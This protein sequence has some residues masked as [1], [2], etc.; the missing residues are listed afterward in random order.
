MG[1]AGIS[2]LKGLARTPSVAALA[3][4]QVLNVLIAGPIDERAY[5]NISDDASLC[6]KL[7]LGYSGAKVGRK[8]RWCLLS[9]KCQELCR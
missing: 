1:T 2:C 5:C 6:G 8:G 3:P 4:K 9:N 7:S